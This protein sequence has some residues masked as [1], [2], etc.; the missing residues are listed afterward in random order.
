MNLLFHTEAWNDYQFWQDNKKALRR[1][2]NLI[3]EIQRTP[4]EGTGEPEPLR[5]NLSGWWSRRIDQK[6]RIVYRIKDNTVI[7][8]ACK[9]HYDD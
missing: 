8:A 7:I 1:V 4:F 5:G 3:R 6:H 9:G 2:N